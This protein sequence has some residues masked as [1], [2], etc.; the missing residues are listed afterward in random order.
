[1]GRNQRRRTAQRTAHFDGGLL[2]AARSALALLRAVFLVAVLVG[3]LEHRSPCALVADAELRELPPPLLHFFAQLIAFFAG[4][5]RLDLR[6]VLLRR[7]HDISRDAKL[8]FLK[9]NVA[10]QHLEQ[11]GIERRMFAK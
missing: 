4:A 5:S 6:L 8:V 7:G 9:S 10:I 2:F 3:V 11:G 1:M